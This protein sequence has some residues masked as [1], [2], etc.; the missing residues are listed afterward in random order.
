MEGTEKQI[1]WAIT[2]KEEVLQETGTLLKEFRWRQSV[3]NDGLEDVDP[4]LPI[5]RTLK[6]NNMEG[7][8]AEEVITVF[9]EK[10]LPWLNEQ[11]SAKWWIDNKSTCIRQIFADYLST[12]IKRSTKS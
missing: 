7:A 3:F 8:N 5:R 10:F 12:R 11:E 1:N 4:I 6:I 2:I 9:E